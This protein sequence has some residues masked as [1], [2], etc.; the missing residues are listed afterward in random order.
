MMHNQS[1]I[2]RENR[3]PLERNEINNIYQTTL[4]FII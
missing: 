2:L 3:R 1:Q 4:L